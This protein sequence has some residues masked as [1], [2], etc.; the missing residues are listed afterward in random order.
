MTIYITVALIL[1]ILF[2]VFRSFVAQI[3]PL[4]T[5]GISF[6]VAQG[7][8]AILADTVNFPLSTFTQI[9]MV[10][11]MF[12]IGTDYCILIISRFKE[13]INEHQDRK[14]T[15]LNSSHVAISYAVFCLKKKKNND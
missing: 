6:L 14:S 2:L 8:V 7:I 15:R 11:V 3:I 4:L 12:G 13:E 1:I 9:F 10:A 5:V